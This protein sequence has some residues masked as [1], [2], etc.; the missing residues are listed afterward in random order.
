MN[1]FNVIECPLD[2]GTVKLI[3]ASAGTGKTT[4]IQNLF[5]R[6]LIEGETPTNI[7]QILV[8]TY[9]EAATAELIIR[10]RE[11]LANAIN[12]SKS[13]EPPADDLLKK[14]LEKANKTGSTEI[15][16][17]RLQAALANFDEA[18]ICTIHG[19]C[20]RMLNEFAVESGES[21]A[22]EL[23]SDDSDLFRETA[24]DFYRLLFFRTDEWLPGVVA[25][26][27][28]FTMESL[29]NFA[30][31]IMKN[32]ECAIE[33]GTEIL[34]LQDV[35]YTLHS[36]FEEF[37]QYWDDNRDEIIAA[38]EDNSEIMKKAPCASLTNFIGRMQRDNIDR[39]LV[40]NTMNDLAK[41][42]ITD[43]KYAKKEWC[44][45]NGSTPSVFEEISDIVSRFSDAFK[46]Y[47]KSI[48][49]EFIQYTRRP[50]TLAAKKRLMQ[51][52]TF[53]DLLI[54][55]RNALRNEI[56][57]ERIRQR[58][59][60]VMIDEFQDTDPVQYE[61]FNTV[62]NHHD[63]LM[64]MVGDPKQS[65]Y[66]F[67]GADIYSYIDAGKNLAD[68]SNIFT[69]TKNYR[70]CEKMLQGFNIIF[71]GKNPFV[72]EKIAYHAAVSGREIGRLLV[73]SVDNFT[74]PLEIFPLVEDEDSNAQTVAKH[75]NFEFISRIVTLLRLAETVNA[76]GQPMARFEVGGICHAVK[77]SDIAI[78]TYS[79]REARLY[80]KKLAATGIPAVLQNSGNVFATP[81]AREIYHVMN[82]ILNPGNN[83]LLF[84]ALTTSILGLDAASINIIG[85]DE[86]SGDEL[87]KYRK[88]FYDLRDLWQNKGFMPMFF[89]LQRGDKVIHRKESEQPALERH[90]TDISHLAELLHQMARSRQLSMDGLLNWLQERI[91][92]GEDDAAY[93]QRLES[94]DDA[95]KILTVH[96]SKGLQFPIV[97]CPSLWGWGFMP[98]KRKEEEFFF[99]RET[100]NGYKIFL[101]LGTKNFAGSQLYYRREKLAEAVR[102]F[103]V[104]V[105][106]A[107]YYCCIAH[108]EQKKKRDNAIEYL[109]GNLVDST[110]SQYL[111]TGTPP[112]T[113]GAGVGIGSAW[114]QS[115]NIKF[116]E[117]AEYKKL[118]RVKKETVLL[119]LDGRNF[120]RR[121]PH[122]FRIMSFSSMTAG[123]HEND[124]TPGG[125]ETIAAGVA[126]TPAVAALGDSQPLFADFPSGALSGDCIHS[127]LEK[128][129]FQQIYE[130]G[131]REH[132][133]VREL[134]EKN[135]IQFGRVDGN[136]G[137]EHYTR[138]LEARRRQICAMLEQVLSTPL[139][140][141][142]V[143][144]KIP[145]RQRLAELE[146][147]FSVPDKIQ[148]SRLE[149]LLQ[150][151]FP[152]PMW[153]YRNPL[154]EE[155]AKYGFMNGKIDL[156]FQERGKYWLA[157]WKTNSLGMPYRNYN[158]TA[159]KNSMISS[160][161]LAQAAIYTVALD[162][163]L[164][165]RLPHY[166][167]EKH[168]GGA[169]Y[170]YTR[171]MNGESPETG[172]FHMP[173]D[174]EML[175]RLKEI[176]PGGKA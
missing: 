31:L 111:L 10:I 75:S 1:E 120:P 144:A 152:S 12:A 69:L 165:M 131:W 161:Y 134:I 24:A 118:E 61:I 148:I 2:F 88:E 101:E 160:F 60:V 103:Y 149:A 51:V 146:F 38:F 5:I 47:V 127:I 135:L 108:R 64:L 116:S 6:L 132:P 164:T 34:P 17:L 104:A 169:F 140:P 72:E 173:Y 176:F 58:F 115:D 77:P 105:T 139:L 14:I 159:L 22:T 45:G 54:N 18:S 166:T 40:V 4:A 76:S 142:I 125:E 63:T 82:G 129:D 172:V 95:V 56:F 124:F 153:Q 30:R 70:S 16:R 97:F 71:G 81:E 52:K 155:T 26:E 8:V 50:D 9:T 20:A 65:I 29:Q 147:Y 7:S 57:A 137:S 154:G 49:A 109:T 23:V 99:H 133:E 27:C 39:D 156:V 89:S 84:T 21:F 41:N 62:F 168:L 25:A 113:V 37:M 74:A 94:D 87:E 53:D 3:E 59:K 91:T 175:E 151:K 67:R 19:F 162:R 80:C 123:E 36:V 73:E 141:G 158:Q 11:N 167:P 171:G 106:R 145:C 15:I 46:I 100:N 112:L 126:T 44:T 13:G 85:N 107:K 48:K 33:N 98:G 117:P 110:I 163:F 78:L 96:K 122:D 79:N 157:D 114:R 92:G 32:P 119:P 66:A 68:Q 136:A 28:K 138:S 102:L 143:L 174:R 42:D 93:E 130:P 55:T 90:L 170:L 43:A 83:R 86:F 35:E 150:E 128:F 121:V